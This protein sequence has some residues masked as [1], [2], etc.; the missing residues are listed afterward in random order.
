[1]VCGIYIDWVDFCKNQPPGVK[2]WDEWQFPDFAM[3][4]KQSLLFS[5][6]CVWNWIWYL[7]MYWNEHYMWCQM[8]LSLQLSCC[9]H[10]SRPLIHASGLW[11]DR[12]GPRGSEVPGQVVLH[13]LTHPAGS[14]VYQSYERPSK[15]LPH[16]HIEDGIQ[17]AMGVSHGLCDL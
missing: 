15:L 1:M 12:S 4:L 8:Y 9:S 13:E 11:V 2:L 3:H 5:D 7:H 14:L 10:G 17:A 6:D 16:K